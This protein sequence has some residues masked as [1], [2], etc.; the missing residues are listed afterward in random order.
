M[1]CCSPTHS[2]D[3]T[4]TPHGE[5]CASL[6]VLQ[7]VDAATV[8]RWLST[9]ECV[10]VDVREQD[11]HARERIDGAASHPLGRFRPDLACP[12]GAKR[13]VF[14]CRSGRRSA[15]A[16]ARVCSLTPGAEVY[17]LS[18]GIEGWK[19]AGL[20]TI[21]VATGPRLSVLQQT[22]LAI[23]LIVLLGV[24]FGAFVSPW[25][26]VLPGF[27]GAGLA[28]AGLTGTCGLAT[29][30]AKLPWNKVVGATCGGSCASAAHYSLSH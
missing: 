8:Q 3:A 19:S 22:Q 21:A 14:H 7:E 10:L 24:L 17:T 9:G 16:G 26:L 11:E 18:G 2:P 20:P 13:V 4:Q 23:G 12:Q 30:I 1:S 25:F 28:V 15:D 29:V 5:C 27:M 6:N